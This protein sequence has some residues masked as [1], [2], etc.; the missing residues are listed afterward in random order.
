MKIFS[1]FDTQLKEETLSLE[2]EK[3]GEKSVHMIHRSK[4]FLLLNTIVPILQA[5]LFTTIIIISIHY[6]LPDFNYPTLTG[7]IIGTLVCLILYNNA[8]SWYIDYTMDYCIITPDDIIL[9]QQKW[10]LSRLVRTLDVAKIKSIHTE[11]HSLLHSIFNTWKIVFMSD[12]DEEQLWEIAFEYISDPEWQKK[13]I[14]R[15]ISENMYRQNRHN[16]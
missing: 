8:I 3:H 6:L 12:G 11:K 4:L 10:F 16:N 1:T 5:V 15:I 2:I 13:R 7:T 9:T 14:Q